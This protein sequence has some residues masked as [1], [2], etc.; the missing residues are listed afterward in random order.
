[1]TDLL[2]SDG[3]LLDYVSFLKKFNLGCPPKEYRTVCRAIPLALRQLICNIMLYIEV[4]PV[5]PNLKIGNC[6]M[7]DSKCNNKVISLNFK[8]IIFHELHDSGRHLQTFHGDR[9][10]ME[11]AFSKFVKFPQK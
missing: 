7:N 2:D 4:K 6:N 1:M 10:L 9:S 5:L 11:K 3:I 8:L